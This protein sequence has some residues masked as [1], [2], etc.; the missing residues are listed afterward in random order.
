LYAGPGSSTTDACS[1]AAI[2]VAWEYAIDGK[3]LCLL[4]DLTYEGS[5][6]CSSY[7][8]VLTWDPDFVSMRLGFSTKNIVLDS[9]DDNSGKLRL[10]SPKDYAGQAQ[11]D[12]ESVKVCGSI[13]GAI[14]PATVAAADVK[15]AVREALAECQ[16]CA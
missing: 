12:E 5:E 4:L 2:D 1:D 7:A 3:E 10:S 14:D 15:A 8:V 6:T 9:Q 11:N 13:R 16:K